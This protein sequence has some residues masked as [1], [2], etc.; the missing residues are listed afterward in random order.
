M[1]KYSY[2]FKESSK[3]HEVAELFKAMADPTRLSLLCL[4]LSGNHSV[5]ELATAAKATPSAVSHQLRL[6]RNL[7]LVS[8]HRLG[9][10]IIYQLADDHV[11][12]LVQI[13]FEHVMEP[14]HVR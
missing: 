5:S 7:H 14:R 12:S 13:A 9:K 3:L 1:S 6:L 2:V 11:K 8:A 4:L 10:H